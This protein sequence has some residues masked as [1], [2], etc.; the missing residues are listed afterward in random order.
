MRALAEQ[1]LWEATMYTEEAKVTGAVLTCG[2]PHGLLLFTFQ[3]L[4]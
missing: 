3:K 1:R 4:T 2:E